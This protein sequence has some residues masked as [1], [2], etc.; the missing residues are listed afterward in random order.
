MKKLILAAAVSTAL[1]GG[2]AQA[3]ITVDGNGIPVINAATTYEIFLSGSSAA[4]PFIES[5]MTSSKVPVANRIC[6]SSQLIYQFKDTATSGK[7]QNAYLC[8]LNTAN[9]ALKGLAAGKT[10]LLLYKR[11]NGGSAQ[12][13]NPVVADAAIDFLKVDTAANC[14]VASTGVAGT[15]FTKIN[16]D[17][18]AGNVELSNPQKPDFGMSDVD[19]AQFFG[20]NT[21]AGF[22]PVTADDVNKLTVKAAGALVFGVPVTKK[23]RDAMQEAQ[24]GKT[25]ACVGKETTACMPSL[26][27]AQI[28]S[29]FT[30]KLNSWK[31]L[32]L[33]ASSDLYTNASAANKPAS[34]RL[35]ICRR[36][37]GSGTGAQFGIKF[38]NYPCSD[39]A[40]PSASETGALPETVAKAQIHEN[41]SAGVVSEC[42]SELDSGVNTV[43]TAFNNTYGVRWAIGIQGTEHNASGSFDYR[44]IK[45]DGVE[46]SLDQVARGKYK[47]WVELTYQYNKTHAFDV[48]EQSIVDEL[49]KQ[50]GNPV[51]MAATNLAAVHLWGQ[52]GF[53]ATPQFFAAPANGIIAKDKPINPFSHG[54]TDATTNNCRIP[55]IYNPG[56]TGG[57]Q[58]K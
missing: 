55:A 45:I 30:G 48:S 2:A 52:G 13:V 26:S 18:T 34:D 23:L 15:S 42:L 29:I 16:C 47:D 8:V 10:N 33:G 49:I 17:Y 53:L 27:S 14:A 24:F 19:P 44:Y 40:T 35:H 25:H 4:Q 12:G 6:D 11:N 50:A 54:T 46:P 21:P 38:L 56:A 36:T 3:A 1:L 32:K 41:S 20:Q 37:N 43:G 57:M 51:V 9:P 5:L 31:Q 58:I 39:V 22:A 28:A 7:D